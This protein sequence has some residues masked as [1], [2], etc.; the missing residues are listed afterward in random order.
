MPNEVLTPFFECGVVEAI[1]ITIHAGRFKEMGDSKYKVISYALGLAFTYCFLNYFIYLLSNA[2]GTEFSWDVIVKAIEANYDSLKIGCIVL[3]C[4]KL[5][6]T[7]SA[8]MV[9]IAFCMTILMLNKYMSG[10]RYLFYRI[11]LMGVM[12]LGFG[13]YSKLKSNI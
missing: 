7:R 13:K 8:V 12:L 3:I 5:L 11:A 1:V 2:L 10:P 6:K 9:C 4:I